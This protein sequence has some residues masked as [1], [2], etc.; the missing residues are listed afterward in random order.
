VQEAWFSEPSYSAWEA[1]FGGM[2]VS[3]AQRLESMEAEDTINLPHA[4]V[5][6]VIVPQ[7][8]QFNRSVAPEA[9]IRIERG[10]GLA[11]GVTSAAGLFDLA[12]DNGAPVA[13]RD[14][15]MRESD[16]DGT[17]DVVVGRPY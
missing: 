17:A 1:K 14:I 9:M 4:E 10:L 13:L 12:R 3:D 15:G 8:I 16:L 7:A 5:H 6:T 11:S 2:K